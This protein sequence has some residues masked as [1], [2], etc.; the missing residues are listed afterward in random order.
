MNP[1]GCSSTPTSGCDVRTNEPTQGSIGAPSPRSPVKSAHEEASCD[2]SPGLVVGVAATADQDGAVAVDDQRMHVLTIR[3]GQEPLKDTYVGVDSERAG[4]HVG[5]TDA[6]CH[7]A[8][9]EAAHRPPLSRK[10]GDLDNGGRERSRCT[11]RCR[12]HPSR[13]RAFDPAI[14]PRLLAPLKGHHSQGAICREVSGQHNVGPKKSATSDDREGGRAFRL[15]SF[16][17]RSHRFSMSAHP[18]PVQP[19][20]PV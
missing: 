4:Q 13:D 10:N 20:K 2:S 17:I 9:N 1:Y 15:V 16:A 14:Y 3:N 8:V 7:P 18:R 6:S 11:S 12:R 5:V 19:R